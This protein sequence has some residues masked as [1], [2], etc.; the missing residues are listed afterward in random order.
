LTEHDDIRENLA[1][2]GWFGGG[3]LA[4]ALTVAFTIGWVLLI[5]WLIGDRS[6]QRDWQYGTPSYVP[7]ESIA[8]VTPR[9]HGQPPKQIELPNVLPGGQHATR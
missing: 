6:A 2:S 7:G 9:S 4:P 3:W 1:N 5:W 8:T